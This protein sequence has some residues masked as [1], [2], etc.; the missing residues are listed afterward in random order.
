MGDK[1]I[2]PEQLVFSLSGKFYKVVV[3]EEKEGALEGEDFLQQTYAVIT[4]EVEIDGDDDDEEEGAEKEPPA[5]TD[6]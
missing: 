1:G 4:Q 3:G 2:D 5:D 6:T